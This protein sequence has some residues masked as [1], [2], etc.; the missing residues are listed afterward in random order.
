MSPPLFPSGPS[1]P[2][3]LS[4]TCCWMPPEG[5]CDPA[6]GIVLV[7]HGDVDPS[8]CQLSREVEKRPGRPS[9]GNLA[10]MK[11]GALTMRKFA[12][13]GCFGTTQKTPTQSRAGAGDQVMGR[14]HLGQQSP[15]AP[16]SLCLHFYSLGQP[17][18]EMHCPQGI[19]TNSLGWASIQLVLSM[20]LCAECR[21]GE[22]VRRV[23][24]MFS[25]GADLSWCC[26]FLLGR[27]RV[28]L[29]ETQTWVVLESQ[30]GRK[31]RDHPAWSPAKQQTLHL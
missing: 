28:V 9:L 26:G 18:P 22:G 23:L 29:S 27:E 1:S 5:N 20:C 3:H 15:C 11:D 2:K 31:L 13:L 6:A 10:Q 30:T 8:R 12:Q 4:S 21:I 17:A 19:P 14:R 16:C 7:L 24:G 25:V